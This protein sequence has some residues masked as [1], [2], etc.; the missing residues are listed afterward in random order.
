MRDKEYRFEVGQYVGRFLVEAR[1]AQGDQR[2]HQSREHEVQRK[3]A[4][5]PLDEEVAR[6][7][8]RG[9]CR[10]VHD[11]AADDEE[12]IDAVSAVVQ[13]DQVRCAAEETVRRVRQHHDGR[14][15]RSHVLDRIELAAG[16][17]PPGWRSV[18]RLRHSPTN[19]TSDRKRP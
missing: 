17:G 15:N 10:V 5:E 8:A 4:Y 16:G 9:E 6:P 1:G 18:E 11:E 13:V 2:K 19:V 12:D 7:D 14:R 3:D